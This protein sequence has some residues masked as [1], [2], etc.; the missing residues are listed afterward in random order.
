MSVFDAVL[1]SASGDFNKG[2]VWGF[3]FIFF[4]QASTFPLFPLPFFHVS[5]HSWQARQPPL[6][7]QPVPR[8]RD[9]PPEAA[10]LSTLI[11]LGAEISGL[12]LHFIV[13]VVALQ[14]FLFL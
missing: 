5:I 4:F 2:Y 11:F 13:V 7:Q 12:F 8:R 14:L 3:L 6:R 10:L 1:P 9:A